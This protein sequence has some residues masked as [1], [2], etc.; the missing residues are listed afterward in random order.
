M[1]STKTL[2]D[3]SNI[4]LIDYG[5]TFTK[6]VAVDVQE[7]RLLGC[8]SACTT[9]DTDVNEGLAQALSELERQIGKTEFHKRLACSSAAGGLR[10]VAIGLTPELTAKAAS[11]AAMGAGAKIIGLY[12]FE[13]TQD[14]IAEIAAKSPDILLLTGGTDGGNKK[15]IQHNA[16]MLADSP[17]DFPVIVAGN[18]SSAN[19]I[20]KTLSHR[21]VYICDNVMPSIGKLNIEPARKLIREIFLERIVHAKGLS[22]TVL[23]P[24]P[25]AVLTAVEL[26]AGD[27]GDLIAIDVGGA[28]TDVYS[29]A[30]GS[31]RNDSV[32]F[33]GLR[34]PY[35]KRTVEGDIGMRHNAQGIVEAVGIQPVAELAGLSEKITAEQVQYLME[36]TETLPKTAGQKALDFT[37]AAM[38]IKTATIRHA[39]SLEEA[40]TASGR[41]LI[42]TGKDLTDVQTVIL[43]GGALLNTDRQKELASHALFS[44]NEPQSLRPKKAKLLIDKFYILAAMGL[45]SGYEPQAALKIMKAC[46]TR[47]YD[48]TL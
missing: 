21:R 48:A 25:A 4:L 1:P 11:M 26:L 18:R 13:L 37:L 15:S 28:T 2:V 14:D 12:S 9:V 33:K 30:D 23:M 45:L 36:H 38:A 47:C 27:V 17:G 10:M 46:I 41:V 43:T 44:D 7:P 32:L 39:G 3:M 35:A 24:T 29:I 40:Y 31:P 6:V 42:Q 8:A 5:S 34:E 16:K 22:D 19:E 20:K